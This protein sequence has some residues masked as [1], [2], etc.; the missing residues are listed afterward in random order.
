LS[1][2]QVADLAA[3]VQ[4]G[5]GRSAQGGIAIQFDGTGPRVRASH[6]QQGTGVLDA[7]AIQEQRLGD[8]PSDILYLELCVRANRGERACTQ[9][10]D[11]RN[12]DN[13]GIVVQLYL[14]RK[15]AVVVRQDERAKAFLS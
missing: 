11:V 8:W 9:R 6:A 15:G 4:R 14:S 7:G 2:A 5:T 13:A 1:G 10:I 12:R 3:N